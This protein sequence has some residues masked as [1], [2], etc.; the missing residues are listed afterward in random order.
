MLHNL[1][2]RGHDTTQALGLLLS[3]HDK[4]RHFLAVTQRVADSD[5]FCRDPLQD[6]LL[7]VQRYFQISY[8]LH[9]QDEEI[10]LT[11]LLGA[12][13]DELSVALSVMQREHSELDEGIQRM[14]SC[15]GQTLRELGQLAPD[16]PT[17]SS[18]LIIEAILTSFRKQ[19][20]PWFANLVE[21]MHRH[22]RHE[23]TAIF[24]HLAEV[25]TENIDHLTQAMFARRRNLTS[26]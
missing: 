26:S 13:S 20:T 14:L 10:E 24:C 25:K 19:L 15:I 5:V 11:A 21:K 2:K 9:A 22:L 4:I 7:A 17:K 3:C 18:D 12:H 1:G 8:P 16:L 6:A 23:E